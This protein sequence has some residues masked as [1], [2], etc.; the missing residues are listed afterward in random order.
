MISNL[1]LTVLLSLSMNSPSNPSNNDLSSTF[2]NYTQ[3]RMNLIEYFSNLTTNLPVNPAS[4][5]VD[6]AFCMCVSYYDSF[7]NDSIIPEIFD[8]SEDCY[9]DGFESF[10]SISSPGIFSNITPSYYSY[11]PLNGNYFMSA[12]QIASYTSLYDDYFVESILPIFR[13]SLSFGLNLS[14]TPSISSYLDNAIP[15]FNS[16]TTNF[17]LESID[18][19]DNGFDACVDAINN[20]YPI[21]FD[22]FGGVANVGHAVVAFDYDLNTHSLIYHNGFKYGQAP[23]MYGD[24]I[25]SFQVTANNAT[26][27]AFALKPADNSIH[28]CS[29]NYYSIED[30]VATY[31]CP[32]MLNGMSYPNHTHSINHSVDYGFTLDDDVELFVEHEETCPCNNLNQAVYKNYDCGIDHF[33]Y[34]TNSQHTIHY[35][36][37]ESETWTHSVIDFECVGTDIHEGFCFCGASE[38]EYHNWCLPVMVD[39]NLEYVC[40]CGL[41]PLDHDGTWRAFIRDYLHDHDYFDEDFFDNLIDEILNNSP[42]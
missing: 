13:G 21:I 14:L 18:V 42:I 6:V 25:G 16:S 7:Y 30:N 28:I 22:A 31:Y 24:M 8:I 20:G 5:C 27:L 35:G 15:T 26:G 9:N 4:V 11:N 32:C 23:S 12:D 17:D 41:V 10:S 39:N 36:C 40:V 29:D 33:S 37:G 3:E 2:E 19:M 1:F 38:Y 34:P